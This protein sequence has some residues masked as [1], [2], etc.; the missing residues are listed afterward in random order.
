MTGIMACIDGSPYGASVCDHA[1]WAATRLAAPVQIVHA[2][3]RRDMSSVPLDLSGSPD[4][5]ARAAFAAE[6]A[7]LDRQKARVAAM[8][9]HHL[10]E[11]AIARLHTSGVAEVSERLRHGDVADTIADLDADTRLVVIGKR[12]EAAEF[13]KAHLGSNLERVVRASRKP[14]LVAPRQFTPI[15][16]FLVAFDASPSS[17]RIVDHLLSTPLLRDVPGTLLLAGSASGEPA[18]RLAAAGQVLADAG[19]RIDVATQEGEASEAILAR[20]DKGSAD[21]LVMGAYGHSRIRHLIVGSTT[22]VLIQ[23]SALPV[24]VVR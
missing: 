6:V 17:Q 2:L 16:R 12:G 8:R 4:S 3:G 10:V 18:R 20:L 19:Y 24:L 15:C 11:D 5:G 13:A 9:G 22:T 23:T 7:E 1:A 21:L 14:V